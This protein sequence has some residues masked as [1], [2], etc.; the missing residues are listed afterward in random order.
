[1]KRVN[2]KETFEKRDISVKSFAKEAV[3]R[4]AAASE[5]HASLREEVYKGED[6]LTKTIENRTSEQEEAFERCG[7]DYVIRATVTGIS[8]KFIDFVFPA[9]HDY[10]PIKTFHA[11]YDFVDSYA[12]YCKGRNIRR[13]VKVVP[14]TSVKK[15]DWEF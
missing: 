13:Y 10:D 6:L 7:S 5:H 2:M 8:Q 1:M 11:A 15:I 9:E 3:R 12:K 4:C 14:A